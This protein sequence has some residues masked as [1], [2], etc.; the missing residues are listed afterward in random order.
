MIITATSEREAYM[1]KEWLIDNGYTY[2]YSLYWS[3]EW[4]K[5]G[6]AVFLHKGY[7]KNRMNYEWEG[8]TR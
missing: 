5:D 7:T 8:Y 1:A 3:E 6:I 4:D 2:K